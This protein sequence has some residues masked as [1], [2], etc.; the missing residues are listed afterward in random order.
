MSYQSPQDLQHS[1]LARFGVA[2]AVAGF[3]IFLLGIFPQLIGLALTEGIGVVQIAVFVTG[4]GMSELGTY[5]YLYA[6]RHRA[7]PT[8]LREDVGQRLIATGYVLTLASGFADVLGIGTHFGD[9]QRPY[10]GSFQASGVLL[11]I[12]VSMAGLLLYAPRHKG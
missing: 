7:L 8:T 2:L 11:G 12:L 3:F 5:I 4:L 10:L 1:R 9:L 6:T